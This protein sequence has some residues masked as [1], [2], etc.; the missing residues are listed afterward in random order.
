MEHNV[1]VG[2]V[3]RG[4]SGILRLIK[5]RNSVKNRLNGQIHAL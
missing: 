3:L 2:Q 4:V 1:G 5:L